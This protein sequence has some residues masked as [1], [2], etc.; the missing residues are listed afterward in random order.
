MNTTLGHCGYVALVG[1][2]NVGKSTLLNRLIG[3]KI[4]I[5]SRKPQTTR[6]RLLGIKTLGADQIIYVDT[7]GLHRDAQ[8]AINR[9]M[10]R[11]A[12]GALADVD[13]I[14]FLVEATRWLAEDDYV[15]E[16]LRRG[17]APVILGINKI[18]RVKNR[19]EL[20]PYIQEISAKMNFAGVFPLSAEQGDNV[21]ALEAALVPYLPEGILLFPEDQVTDR[22]VRF[23]AAEIIREK[24]I[25]R[26]GEELPYRISVEIERFNEEER[27]TRIHALI[28]VEKPG[29]KAIVIGQQGR[30]LKEIGTQARLDLEQLLERKVFLELW[31][32]VREGWS[33]DERTLQQLGYHDE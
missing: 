28:W 31:V 4:S 27:L 16:L 32:K 5:T 22:S 19:A 2:P 9:Y 33:D 23:L 7:P 18:D 29:Q 25:R 12:S 14:V 11:A 26:L 15:L 10:N 30:L 3:Q 21:E 24:L 13:V 6:H 20:L 17:Q 1:R 8:R